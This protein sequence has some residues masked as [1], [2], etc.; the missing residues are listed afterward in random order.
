MYRGPWPFN[1]KG[2]VVLAVCLIL[3]VAVGSAVGFLGGPSGPWLGLF[4]GSLVGAVITYRSPKYWSEARRREKEDEARLNK[5][6]SEMRQAAME[7]QPKATIGC[8]ILYFAVF[9]GPIIALFVFWL[10]R[11]SS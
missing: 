4:A 3:G 2:T 9:L 11:V 10:L 7:K 8:T 6:I 5:A 1:F